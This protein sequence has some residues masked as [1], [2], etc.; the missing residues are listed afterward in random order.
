MLFRSAQ[1]L[2]DRKGARDRLDCLMDMVD[3]APSEGTP[4]ALVLGAVEQIASEMLAVR[5]NLAEILGPSLDHGAR[6]A[7]VVR[8]IAPREVERL[9]GLDPRMAVMTPVVEGSAQRLGQGLADGHFPKLST[10]LARMVMTELASQRRLRPNDP[11][12]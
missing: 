5:A 12:G 2:A 7:A 4:R 1:G 9:I 11:V 6:L 8:M 3:A 10:A